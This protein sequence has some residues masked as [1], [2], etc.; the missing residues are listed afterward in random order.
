MSTTEEQKQ[1]PPQ[2]QPQ[3]N[4]SNLTFD[5]MLDSTSREARR[6]IHSI[7]KHPEKVLQTIGATGRSL[8]RETGQTMAVIRDKMTVDDLQRGL[9]YADERVAF[10]TRLI[11][12]SVTFYGI[13]DDLS[14]DAQSAVQ[15]PPGQ[16]LLTNQRLLFLSSTMFRGTSLKA[17]EGF[18]PKR[19]PGG[20]EVTSSSADTMWFFPI[21]VRNFRHVE[22]E[23]RR[24]AEVRA[25]VLAEDPQCCGCYTIC[26]PKEW[27]S[28]QVS[29]DSLNSRTLTISCMLPPWGR[30]TEI[31]IDVHQDVP[32]STVKD[33]LSALQLVSPKIRGDQSDSVKTLQIAA[34]EEM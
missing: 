23:V 1:A 15:K 18:A 12:R 2:Q 26:C 29:R 17:K 24:G 33:F 30:K 27:R 19:H 4:Y 20:Y 3:D 22:M 21:P 9:L 25:F 6:N 31:V 32:L 10:P 11:Y 7:H 14:R 28:T 5:D 34:G 13:Q 16:L 8:I